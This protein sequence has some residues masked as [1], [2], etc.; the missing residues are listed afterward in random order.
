MNNDFSRGISFPF[1]VGNRGGIVMSGVSNISAPHIEESIEQILLTFKGE[2][3]M[4]HHFGSDLDTDIFEP[5]E[6]S[7]HNLI[8]YQ[9]KEVLTKYEPRIIVESINLTGEGTTVYVEIVYVVKEYN[10]IHS[11]TTRIGGDVIEN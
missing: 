10:S 3:V 5:N 7:T 4:E 9:I 11:F 6:V 2:R 1:R 8:K